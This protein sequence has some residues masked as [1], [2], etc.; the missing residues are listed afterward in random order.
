MAYRA[1]VYRTG[2]SMLCNFC[3]RTLK[4]LFCGLPIDS[5][6]K[7]LKK[8]P[9]KV[10]Y[11]SRNSVVSEIFHSSQNGPKMR[12]AYS[13]GSLYC[14][15][16]FHSGPNHFSNCSNVPELPRVYSLGLVAV[17]CKNHAELPKWLNEKTIKI[18]KNSKLILNPCLFDI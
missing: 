9:E 16:L 10:A 3:M 8:P 17:V 2:A 14:H 7:K 4:T 15:S 11:L 12:T 13:C 6:V 1:T 18:I 5:I